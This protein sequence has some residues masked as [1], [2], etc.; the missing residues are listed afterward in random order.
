LNLESLGS[1]FLAFIALGYLI[2]IHELGHF[3]VARLFKVRVTTFSLGF[4]PKLW[5]RKPGETR[6][7]VS[8]V[9]L[10][11]YVRMVGEDPTAEVSEEEIPVSFAHKPILQRMAIVA[12]GPVSNLVLAFVIFYL[13]LVIS[14]IPSRTT[15]VG[16][17]MPDNPAA[18]AGVQKGDRVLSV[19]GEKTTDWA[20]MVSA[21]QKNR[22]NPLKMLL[23]RKGK[24]LEV[25]LIPKHVEFTTIFGEQQK[26]YRVGIE[27]GTE[28]FYK[29]VDPISAISLAAVDV[30]N[31]GSLI[32]RSVN[33][34][35]QAK[36]DLDSVGGP[37]QITQV[38]SEAARVGMDAFLSIVG[39]ISVNLAILNLLPIPAL[40]GGHLF[41]FIMEAIFRK[42]VSIKIR[43]RSQQ[44]GMALLLLLIIV[45][46]FKDVLRIITG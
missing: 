46:T 24:T 44:V 22:G 37:L 14:G 33:A 38:A 13:V 15:L 25:S 19:N 36:V 12:A 18:L 16:G 28:Y 11:G 5:S 45:V 34:L 3:L 2:F 35:V 40:D 1:Y 17:V 9:P 30:Y 8:A 6:Y 31:A 20:G 4:G 39:L 27:A 41:F 29:T 21:I 32:V 42:P 43:E 10:G 7:Q 26:Y 23:E